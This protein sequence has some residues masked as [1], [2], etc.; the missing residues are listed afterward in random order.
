MNKLWNDVG[1]PGLFIAGL[2]ALALTA[3]MWGSNRFSTQA[4]LAPS[5]PQATTEKSGASGGW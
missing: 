4:S 5:A 2:F 3:A 1:L